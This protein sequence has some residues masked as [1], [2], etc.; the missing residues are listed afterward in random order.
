MTS[1]LRTQQLPQLLAAFIHNHNRLAKIAEDLRQKAERQTRNARTKKRQYGRNKATWTGADEEYY[2]TCFFELER[3]RQREI[4]ALQG[5][6][7]RQR[8][9]ILG[10]SKKLRQN[11]PPHLKQSPV[12]HPGF[13]LQ[14]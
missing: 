9:A 3:E 14:R 5:K 12:I 2:L 1:H 6:L 13:Y 11:N 8:Q 7:E 4:C 10:F